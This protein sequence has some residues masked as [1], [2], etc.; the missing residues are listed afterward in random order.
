LV[1]TAILNSMRK[2]WIVNLIW[3]S[4]NLLKF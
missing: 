2:K 4:K 3:D 1:I